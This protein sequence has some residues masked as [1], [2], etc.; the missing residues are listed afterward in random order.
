[1]KVLIGNA[2]RIVPANV[3]MPT[4]AASPSGTRRGADAV[5]GRTSRRNRTVSSA[6]WPTCQPRNHA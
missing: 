2:S 1:M 5:R 6:T 3:W 4:S